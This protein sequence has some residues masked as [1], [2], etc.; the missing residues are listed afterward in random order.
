MRKSKIKIYF[1]KKAKYNCW[2][3]RGCSHGLRSGG[4]NFYVYGI[5]GIFNFTEYEA[6]GDFIENN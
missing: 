1:G 4:F 3:L 5:K 2:G 6:W